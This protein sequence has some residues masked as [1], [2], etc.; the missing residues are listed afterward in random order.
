MFVHKRVYI[1][2]QE[3]CFKT[4]TPN[5]IDFVFVNK[6]NLVDVKMTVYP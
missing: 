6:Q 4:F 2:G 1:A 3:N 5:S